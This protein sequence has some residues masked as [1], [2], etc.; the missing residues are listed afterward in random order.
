[1][2]ERTILELAADVIEKRVELERTCKQ[3][4]NEQGDWTLYSTTGC[5]AERIAIDGLRNAWVM[6]DRL[7][8]LAQFRLSVGL[9]TT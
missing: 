5:E 7:N 9:G 6:L 3:I 8:R 2:E 1:M 4:R